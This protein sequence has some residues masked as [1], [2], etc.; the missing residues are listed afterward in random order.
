VSAQ[1]SLAELVRPGCR[2]AVG[3]GIGAPRALSGALS[4]AAAAGGGVRLLLGWLP[5]ADPGLD[6]GA[7][8]D[9]RAVMSGWGLR[10]PVENGLVRALPV[11]LSTVPALL[12]G[13][14]RPDLLVASVV[15]AADGPGYVF[16]TEISWMRAAVDAG[17]RVA[18]VVLRAAPR[19]CDPGPP[20][21]EDRLVIVGE[22]DTPPVSLAFTP[23]SDIH[24]TIAD[25]VAGLVPAGA[26]VQVGP[27]AMGLAVLEALREPVRIDTGLLPD[28]VLDLD[29]R[30]LLLGTPVTTY[31]AGGPELLAWA[32]GKPLL[33]RAE[34]THDLTRL[35][36]GEPFVAVNTA[37]EIDE[38]GQVNVEGLPGAAV[39]GIG[40]HSDYAVA[41][42]RSAAG[43]S[44]VALASTHHGRPT[45]VE[46]LSA[47]VSTV[48][49]DIDVVVTEHGAADL[50]G[51]DRSERAAALRRLW[52]G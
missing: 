9:V 35:S 31:L 36:T 14:L 47:P 3:D 15:A 51:L 34:Y 45:L 28:G 24:R 40:G 10:R 13:P 46:R 12:R 11:R 25:R 8:A 37:I 48:G 49:H 2:V 44:V 43:L 18:A 33:C 39:G 19:G 20:L 42:A 22:S 21:P 30:G 52:S 6:Y 7:F 50:R 1:P 26:R 41:A 16:A 32:D 5:A 17:A 27:G 4:A 29:R 38:Q 23:P